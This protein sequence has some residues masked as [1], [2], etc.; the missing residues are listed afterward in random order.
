MDEVKIVL[1]RDGDRVR[2]M[3][4]SGCLT[5]GCVDEI[6]NSILQEQS[7]FLSSLSIQVED[8]V[9]FDL[10]FLQL[11]VSVCGY[12]KQKNIDV[13]I[14]WKIDEDQ[15]RLIVGSGFSKLL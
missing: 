13:K 8:V 12:L 15:K 5:I 2:G 10:T 3:V 6:K 1:M 4:L 7:S 9:A 11:L 14:D